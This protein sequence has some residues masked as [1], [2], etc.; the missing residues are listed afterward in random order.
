MGLLKFFYGYN[1]IMST[2]LSM[3][4][5]TRFVRLAKSNINNILKILEDP[6]KVMNQAIED[7]QSDLVK[8]RQSY[9]ELT[10]MHRRLHKQKEY[11]DKLITD[12]IIKLNL[13][14]V[15]VMKN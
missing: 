7:M 13:L 9:A 2:Q 8:I 6:V 3:N 1:K 10:A 5:L 12:C 15:K 14:F 11:T 4:L